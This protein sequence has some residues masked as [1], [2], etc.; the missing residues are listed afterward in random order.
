MNQTVWADRKIMLLSFVAAGATVIAGILHLT[1]VSQSISRDIGQGILFLVGGILQ[2]FW[3]VPVIK[4]WGR[5]WQIIGI[6][7]TAVFVILFYLSR[8]HLI[9]EANILGGASHENVSQED[10]QEVT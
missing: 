3:A 7:G 4:R 1:M 8:F 5:V 9:P 2:V 6:V 10:L